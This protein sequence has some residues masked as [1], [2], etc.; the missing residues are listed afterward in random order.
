MSTREVLEKCFEELDKPKY[1]SM[2]FI[3]LCI[4]PNFNL[5]DLPIDDQAELLQ[6]PVD[7]L[8]QDHKAKKYLEEAKSKMKK[9]TQLGGAVM[10]TKER[11]VEKI[12]E[13]NTTR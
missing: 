11:R 8:L 7:D 4:D 9:K 1:N 12:K 3:E 10:K 2:T 6:I 5:G 13:R